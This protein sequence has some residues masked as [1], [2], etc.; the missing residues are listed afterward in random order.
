MFDI[1]NTE[2]V[3][4]ETLRPSTMRKLNV[5]LEL[6]AMVDALPKADAPLMNRIAIG[7]LHFYRRL[8]P[9]SIGNRC[10]FEPSCSRYSELAF[11]Q[12]DFQK[13]I[14]LTTRRLSRCKPGNGGIDL[15]ELETDDAI[16][17]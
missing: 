15:T 16:S 8:R 1:S 3:L 11:R 10:V 9:K 6:D 4:D 12:H 7:A 17:R 2:F 13:S 14:T 5:A